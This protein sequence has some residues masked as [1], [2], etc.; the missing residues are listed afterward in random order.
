MESRSELSLDLFDFNPWQLPPSSWWSKAALRRL[1]ADLFRLL[2]RSMLYVA[3][4]PDAGATYCEPDARRP[5]GLPR[6]E[7]RPKKPVP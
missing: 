1:A 3:G 7:S 5:H 6:A 4:R 2:W